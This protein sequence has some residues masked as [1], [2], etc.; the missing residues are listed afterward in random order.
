MGTAGGGA[1]GSGAAGKASVPQYARVYDR[2]LALGFAVD[3][4]QSVLTA[5]PRVS[6]AR[7]DGLLHTRV[8]PWNHRFAAVA[9]QVADRA[10][11]IT[12]LRLMVCCG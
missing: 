8:A 11:S 5:L 9:V 4:I 7:C 1:G 12:G 2:L 10:R 6:L 3:D